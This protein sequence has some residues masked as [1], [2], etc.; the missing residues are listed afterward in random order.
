MCRVGGSGIREREQGTKKTKAKAWTRRSCTSWWLTPSKFVKKYS[1]VYSICRGKH[2][3]G[4]QEAESGNAGKENLR[5]LRHNCHRTDNPSSGSQK[6]QPCLFWGDTGSGPRLDLPSPLLDKNTELK[7]PLF[8]QGLWVSLGWVWH[9]TA[10]EERWI[11]VWH[12][13]C[14]FS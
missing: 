10:K 3:Q 12:S 9:Y 13:G 7:F 5:F 14:P 11:Y 8:Y 1:I 4:Q 2:G 6:P